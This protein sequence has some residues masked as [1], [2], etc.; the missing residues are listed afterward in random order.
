MTAISAGRWTHEYTGELTVFLIG[1]RIN[2]LRRPD[3]WGPVIAAMPPMLAE[4]AE[5]PESGFLGHQM[6][7]GRRGPVLIQYWRT[8][9]DVYRYASER[10]AAHRPAWSAF[11][12]RAHRVPGA[13]GIWHETFQVSRAESVYVDMPPTGLAAATASMSITKRLDRASARLTRR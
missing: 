7:V 3:A 10:D 9:E 11:N 8:P 6:T 5:D 4:L 13:V 2:R 1:M 12:T